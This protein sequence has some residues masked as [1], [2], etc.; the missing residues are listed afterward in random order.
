MEQSGREGLAQIA[1][2]AQIE[3]HIVVDVYIQ[4]V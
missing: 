2:I 1:Y 4:I 3:L